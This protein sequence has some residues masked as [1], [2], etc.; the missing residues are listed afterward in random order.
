[1]KKAI[2]ALDI[3]DEY[4]RDKNGNPDVESTECSECEVV[5]ES[6]V[7]DNIKGVFLKA[8]NKF[9]RDNSIAEIDVIL[10]PEIDNKYDKNA[11]RVEALLGVVGKEANSVP[12]GYLSRENAKRFRESFPGQ[13]MIAKGCID[14]G[15]WQRDNGKDFSVTIEI[16]EAVIDKYDWIILD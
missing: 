14:G 8:E 1:M 15:Y 6:F 4:E 2:D 5:G 11:V 16:P 7:K 12:V 3:R 10:I 9:G 13:A